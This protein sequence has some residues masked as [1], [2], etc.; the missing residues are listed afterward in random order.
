[1]LFK[2]YLNVCSCKIYLNVC[3]KIY[4]VMAKNGRNMWQMTVEC[5]VF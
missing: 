4:L 1:M 5:M 3:C 2:I